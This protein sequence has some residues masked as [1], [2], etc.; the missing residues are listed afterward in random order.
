MRQIETPTY[1]SPLYQPKH[2]FEYLFVKGRYNFFVQ[3]E[4]IIALETS[5]L[6]IVLQLCRI[7]DE[8]Q[9][10]HVDYEDDRYF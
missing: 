2:A 1:W 10:E 4:N 9:N 3:L 7:Y 6:R 8:N 5:Q